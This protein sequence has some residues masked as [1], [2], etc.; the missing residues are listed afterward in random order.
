MSFPQIQQLETNDEGKPYQNTSAIELPNDE[1]HTAEGLEAPPCPAIRSNVL[2][3]RRGRLVELP[4]DSMS[5]YD[6]VPG[7]VYLV[8]GSHQAGARNDII[9]LP[10]PS[11]D[12]KDP[13]AS[14]KLTL[15]RAYSS[16]LGAL[17]NW[18]SVIYLNLTA[19]YR[20]PITNLNI[21]QAIMLLL[22]GVGNVFFVPLSNKLGRRSIYIWTLVLVLASQI[23]MIFCRNIGDFQ[24]AHVILGLG[25]APFEALVAISISNVYFAHERGSKLGVYVF[26]LAFGS[27]VGPI[28]AGYMAVDQGWRWIYRWGAILTGGLLVLFY[29]TFEETHFVREV[30]A[31][32]GHVVALESVDEEHRRQSLGAGSLKTKKMD[33]DIGNEL[34]RETTHSLTAG[35]LEVFR[36]FYRPLQLSIFLAVLWCGINYGTCVSWLAVMGTTI[37][38]VFAR[39][40]YLFSPSDLGLIWIFPMI[41]SLI[42]AYFSGPLNDRLTLYL[43]TRNRGWREPEFRLWAFIPSAVIMPCGLIMYGVT[44]AHGLHWITPIVGTGFVGFG[45][46]VGGTVSIAYIVDCYKDIDTQAVTTI[47]LIR[48]IV[49]FAITWGIQPWIDGMGQQNAFI[50]VGVLSFVITG[51]AG[52]FIAW[53]KGMRRWTAGRYAALAA[54]AARVES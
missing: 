24:G 21:G 36:E 1:N 9:L 44:S 29:L 10:T 18:E 30:D 6:V 22:L 50:L 4:A 7:T 16:L 49:G 40:P 14:F 39:P 46:S 28:C 15:I 38:E 26:G 51:F 32:E 17:T 5:D 8:E 43:S 27:F 3:L 2:V 33:Q 41:G 54:E 23:W 48:N 11:S 37:A 20:T 19:A 42:G 25:A 12:I 47:I 13:L 53:G 35:E 45:L 52:V 34:Q 31:Q